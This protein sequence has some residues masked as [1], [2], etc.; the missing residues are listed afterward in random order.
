MP[1]R[2]VLLHCIQAV[3]CFL[4][5]A[6]LGLNVTYSRNGGLSFPN[7]FSTLAQNSV[8]TCRIIRSVYLDVFR[9]VPR[10]TGIHL[11]CDVR[12]TCHK[13]T[14]LIKVTLCSCGVY[15]KY[16]SSFLSVV[17]IVT[18][19]GTTKRLLSLHTSRT[20]QQ[21]RGT[22]RKSGIYTVAGKSYYSLR[23]F[24]CIYICTGYHTMIACF[25]QVLGA[26]HL[27]E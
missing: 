3:F 16:L 23:G 12:F 2:G 13:F 25:C 20:L 27:S 5:N 11:I 7:T 14:R 22:A 19:A 17:W 18:V 26:Y 10:A 24:F 6:R 15:I 8:Q 4:F 9:A 1:C 21:Q